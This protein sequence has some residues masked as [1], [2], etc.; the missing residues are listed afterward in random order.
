MRDVYYKSMYMSALP[1]AWLFV[2]LTTAAQ[3]QV[4]QT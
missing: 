3:A 2:R 1:F 4:L